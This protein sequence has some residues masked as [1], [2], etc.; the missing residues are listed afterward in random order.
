M[1][2]TGRLVETGDLNVNGEEFCGVAF[3]VPR[4]QIIGKTS[5]F[6]AEF[7]ITNEAPAKPKRKVVHLNSVL[8]QEEGCVTLTAYCDDGTFWGRNSIDGKWFQISSIPQDV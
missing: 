4:E 8:D 3:E 7:T 2:M 5:D 1:K 6:M